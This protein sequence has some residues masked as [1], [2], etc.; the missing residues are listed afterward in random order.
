MKDQ[1]FCFTLEHFCSIKKVISFFSKSH[2][3]KQEDWI[4][5]HFKHKKSIKKYYNLIKDQSNQKSQFFLSK[6]AISITIT[7]SP[8]QKRGEKKVFWPFLTSN[9]RNLKKAQF[10]CLLLL[11]P[12]LCVNWK[13]TTG[14][15]MLFFFT[16]HLLLFIVTCL[17][18]NVWGFETRFKTLLII[19]WI[20]EY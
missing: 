4:D 15:K 19:L 17:W 11:N 8:G 10:F 1:K 3:N 2:S 7:F 13:D 20:S 16:F 5:P 9:K 12:F 14:N 18:E 6:K